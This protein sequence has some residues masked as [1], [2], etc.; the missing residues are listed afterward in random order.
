[1]KLKTIASI[2]LLLTIGLTLGA[3][4]TPTTP[5]PTAPPAASPTISEEPTPAPPVSE[6]RRGGVLRVAIS[7]GFWGLD[8]AH[9]EASPD[10]VVIDMVYEGLVR[11]DPDT[12]EPL[13]L[14]AREWDISEDGLTYTFYLQEGVK[15]HNGDDF[16]A[17]DVKYSVERILDPE[18]GSVKLSYLTAIESVEVADDHTVVFHL[19][20]P[21]SPLMS[22]L[23]YVPKIQ[24]QAFVEEHEGQTLRTMMGTGPFVFKEWAAEVLTLERNPYYW[25]LGED[26]QPLPYLDG[27]ELYPYP[28]EDARTASLLSGVIDIILEPPAKDVQRLQRD[29]AVVVTKPG[30]MAHGGVWF[31]CKTPPFD[32][33]RVRQAV[34]WALDRDEMVSAGYFGQAEPLYGGA[35]PQGHWAY[36][37]LRVYDHRDV[38]KAKSLL[39]QAGYPEGFECTIPAP[40]GYPHHIATAEMTVGYLQDIGVSCTAEVVEVATFITNLVGGQYPIFV[41]ASDPTGDPDETYYQNYHTDGAFNPIG[42]SNSDVDR[43]LEKAREISDKD[44]RRELYRQVEEILIQEQPHALVALKG[45]SGAHHPNVKGFFV[46]PNNRKDGLI[47]TWLD[48]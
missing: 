48:S 18:E 24:N 23:P 43:L 21:F 34:S 33:A 45:Y 37:G 6:I 17:D 46:M 13:P 25:R 20:K 41:V 7:A 26:G 16:V 47:Y 31:H 29:P 8:P 9:E 30:G 15:W 28:D 19:N 10:R 2:S 11:W 38:D 36:T 22:T 12:L 40:A 39:A 35:M 27:M 3:C 44:Q 32:D 1:M 14:L 5:P 4:A 42:Y